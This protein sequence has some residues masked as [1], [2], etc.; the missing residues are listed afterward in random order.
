[1]NMVFF[2]SRNSHLNLDYLQK[3][4]NG[5]TF[6]ET[7]TY[8]GETVFLAMQAGFQF[9]HSIELN[10]DLY[11][12]A[13]A[14]FINHRG[15]KIWQGDSALCLPSVIKELKGPAT[16]WLDAHAS[17]NLGGGVSG[18]SPVLDELRIIQAHGCDEH[19][20]FIDDRRLFGSAEWSFVKEQDAFDLLREINPN[21]NIHYLNGHIPGDVICATV[22]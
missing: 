7:G 10:E 16:F 14:K 1:M 17:G 12:K 8:M 18:G 11:L 5:D 22:K 9:I 21:Y 4:G 15:I 6:V 2:D 3:Y 20:I 19:T 13:T